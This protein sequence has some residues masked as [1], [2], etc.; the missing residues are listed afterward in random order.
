MSSL[1]SEDD[2]MF[3]TGYGS[4][5]SDKTCITVVFVSFGM[6]T[7]FSVRVLALLSIFLLYSVRNFNMCRC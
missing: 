1:H 5:F 7:L 3:S 4:L 6:S 2:I